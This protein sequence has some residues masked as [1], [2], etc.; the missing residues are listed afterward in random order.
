MDNVFVD[1]TKNCVDLQKSIS[2]ETLAA[3]SFCKLA[4][5]QIDNIIVNPN[6]CKNCVDPKMHL[7]RDPCCT[8]TYVRLSIRIRPRRVKIIIFRTGRKKCRLAKCFLLQ[9]FRRVLDVCL[10]TG[11]TIPTNGQY[12]CRPVK[13]LCP[14]EKCISSETL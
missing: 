8:T 14:S 6:N 13:E 10:L 5:V 2:L 1:P 7:S 3:Y 12:Y 9:K 4:I 11:F